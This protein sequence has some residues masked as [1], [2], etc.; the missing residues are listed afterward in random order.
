MPRSN[1]E[2]LLRS[3]D[4]ALNDCERALT[5]LKYMSDMYG[6]VENPL[7]TET[8]PQHKEV[9]KDY[10]GQHGKYQQAVDLIAMQ[11][12]MAMD[13]LKTFKAEFM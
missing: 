4:Q 1:R 3:A 9:P 7:G 5:N 11:I 10:S 6:G 12:M 13:D 8:L 2:L